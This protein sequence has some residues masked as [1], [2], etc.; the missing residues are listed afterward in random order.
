MQGFE[1]RTWI[2]RKAALITTF[3]LTW[4]TVASWS[5]NAFK[6]YHDVL[7][8]ALILIALNFFEHALSHKDKDLEVYRWFG[9][10]VRFEHLMLFSAFSFFGIII[11]PLDSQLFPDIFHMAATGLGVAGLTFTIA[12]WYVTGTKNWWLFMTLITISALML[13]T[14]FAF[15]VPWQVGHGEFAILLAGLL[16]FNKIK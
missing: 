1:L 10:A 14:A 7:N 8:F 13:I 15:N 12:G 11:F 2:Y 3:F 5:Q 16:F 6:Q 4:F 9:K